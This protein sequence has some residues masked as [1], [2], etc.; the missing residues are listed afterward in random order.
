MVARQEGGIWKLTGLTF[1]VQR[2]AEQ[3]RAV[4]RVIEDVRNGRYKDRFSAMLA[5]TNALN[6]KGA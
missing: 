1:N 3:R 5:A 4:E 6:G 2:A